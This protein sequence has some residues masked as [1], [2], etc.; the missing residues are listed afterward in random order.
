MV[1][2]VFI[3]PF[4][5]SF[6]SIW[7]EELLRAKMFPG[8]AAKYLSHFRVPHSD[9]ILTKYK[10]LWDDFERRTTPTPIATTS[11]SSS[12]SAS[13][14]ARVDVDDLAAAASSTFG[15]QAVMPSRAS[16]KRSPNSDSPELVVPSSSSSSSASA[17]GPK[18][19]KR[20]SSN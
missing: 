1:V 2:C 14:H 5:S 13:A 15:A 10:V 9:V 4:F 6:F 12:S 19:K 11:S 7:C 3:Q 8:I 16:K 17:S 18:S 20:K